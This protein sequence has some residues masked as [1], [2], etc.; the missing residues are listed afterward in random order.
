M[1]WFRIQ[2]YTKKKKD[3]LLKQKCKEKRFQLKLIKVSSE[4]N[5]RNLHTAINWADFVSW[6]M[7]Y[8]YDGYKMHSRENDAVLS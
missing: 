4:L 6:C 2:G 1:R 3:L 8:T 5:V 7:L